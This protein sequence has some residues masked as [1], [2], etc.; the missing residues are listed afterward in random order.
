MITA[1]S[2]ATVPKVSVILRK[3]YGAGLYAMSGPA[4]EPEATIALP[5]AKI[6]VMGP[7]PA[8]NA[9]FAN[10][11]AAI[12]DPEERAAFVAEQ[13]RVYEEDVDLL[14][15]ASELVID[16]VIEPGALRREVIAR[17]ALAEGKPRHFSDRRHGVPPV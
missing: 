9:V 17:L 10:K 16:A 1:V 4:F 7:E 2:E 12:E 13:L 11:I 5:T 6:A 14:R 8:V 3:A 15:L